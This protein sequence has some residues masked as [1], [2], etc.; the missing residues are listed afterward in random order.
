MIKSSLLVLCSH[1]NP[2]NKEL[3]IYYLL[4]FSFTEYMKLYCLDL[5]IKCYKIIMEPPDEAV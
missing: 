3:M 2:K 4:N 5:S 1:F